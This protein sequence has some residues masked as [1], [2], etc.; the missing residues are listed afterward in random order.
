[1]IF[2][3][4]FIYIF[5]A[6][7]GR[8]THFKNYAN[9][10]FFNYANG[11][12]LQKQFLFLKMMFKADISFF[13]ISTN[14]YFLQYYSLP[15]LFFVTKLKQKLLFNWLFLYNLVTFKTAL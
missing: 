11:K 7:L 9:F 14:F 1:M 5:T 8:L 12:L 10:F 13:I 15:L 3:K 2:Q 6:Q 4:Y